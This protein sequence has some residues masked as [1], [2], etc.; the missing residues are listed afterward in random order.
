MAANIPGPGGVVVKYHTLPRWRT[1]PL[2]SIPPMAVVL[3]EVATPA[4]NTIQQQWAGEMHYMYICVDIGRLGCQMN[5]FTHA[6]THTHTVSGS[7][8]TLSLA[9][10]GIFPSS[11]S[12][13]NR[14]QMWQQQ[15]PSA[16][17]RLHRPGHEGKQP[18][19]E[20]GPFI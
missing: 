4:L 1:L 16:A 18:A 8:S 3:G 20:S 7:D 14:L 5:P 6:H 9:T 15:Q 19:G 17:G 13:S 12:W 2:T 11:S 10:Q